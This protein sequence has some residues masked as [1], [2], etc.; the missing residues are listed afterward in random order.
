MKWLK[1]SGLVLC[2]VLLLLAVV[3]MFVPLNDYVLLVEKQVSTELREPVKIAGLRAGG[4]P[5]PHV[6]VDGLSIGKAGEITAEHVTITPD[7]WSLLGDSKVIHRIRIDRLTVSQKALKKIVSWSAAKK[8]SGAQQVHVQVKQILLK[9]A[10]IKLEKTAFGPFDARVGMNDD[11]GL[12]VVSV[13]T[14]DRRLRVDVKPEAARYRVDASARDWILPF[15]PALHFN[16]LSVHGFA[17]TNQAI[18][19]KVHGELYGGALDGETT[20]SWVKG[21]HLK[22]KATLSKVE[23]SSLSQAFG[24]APKMSGR[25]NAKPM[26]YANATK[27]D[28]LLMALHL[29]SPFDI[30]DGVLRGVDIEKAATSFFRDED[31]SAQTRFDEISGHLVVDQG[32][33]KFTRLRIAAGGLSAKGRVTV[34]PDGELSGRIT[35]NVE[36]AVASASMPLNVSGTVDSPVV[37]PPAGI[38]AGAAVGTAILGPAGTA[39]GTALGV[40]LEQLFGGESAQ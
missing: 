11:N 16:A 31:P 37:L 36:G 4:L 38:A 26:F 18:F 20:L 30:Q 13:V 8:G 6:T 35:T 33:R 7:L 27:G 15:N 10:L 34:S 23:V 14:T 25:L 5:L 24:Q 22:G 32:A 17:T 29:E 1:V 39:L 19:H 40:K 28:G 2:G 21:I 9:S 3:P 12:D